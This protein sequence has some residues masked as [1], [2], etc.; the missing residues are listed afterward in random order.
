MP[1]VLLLLPTTSYRTTDFMEAARKLGV[2]VVVGS[3]L[4]QVLAAH[5]PGRTL[6]LDFGDSEGAAREVSLFSRTYP[7]DAVIPVDDD[8][9]LVGA[10]VSRA[11]EFPHNPVEAVMAARDKHRFRQRLAEAGILSPGFELF[12]VRDDPLEAAAD[13][14]YPCVIK[15]VFLSASR[16]VIRADGPEAFVEA[17]L[18]VKALLEDPEIASRGREAATKI[19]VEDYLP[20]Q[21]AAL[22]GMLTGGRL[23]VLAL[24]DKPDPL[25]GPFFEETIYVTPSR[26][27]ADV[28]EAISDCAA[29]AAEAIGLHEG[30]VHAE[31][32]INDRGVW[33]I[34]IAA[35]SI[36]GLCSRTL[37]FGTGISL[38]ELILRNA[39]GG[40]GGGGGGEGGMET[41]S[42]E[43]EHRAAGV[44]MIPIPR[45]GRLDEVLGMEEAR[46]VPGI[47]DAVIM[48][49]AGQ[50]VRPLPEGS[51][52]LGFLFARADA[53]AEVEA[54]L[55]EAHGRLD[56][57]ITPVRESAA[58]PGFSPT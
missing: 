51:K 44:M 48:I 49:P 31:V 53:P 15:P 37:R 16:G 2:E 9:A 25:E 46:A 21:E 13:I 38:E 26:L 56:I 47:E 58:H 11:L 28:R 22:E 7:L 50:T 52:Y 6:T 43:R 24:F 17:F 40:R 55:R 12:S 29:R 34:E 5:T 32:R 8:T 35:R 36:G 10:R 30:P 4:P 20:G 23:R 1:R 41:E 42:L 27:P 18:R 54:A 33:P 57:R 14:A 39:L 19:L 3:D 45:A